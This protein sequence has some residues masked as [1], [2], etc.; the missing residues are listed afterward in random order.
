MAEL[1]LVPIIASGVTGGAIITSLAVNSSMSLWQRFRKWLRY[2]NCIVRLITKE[3]DAALFVELIKRISPHCVDLKHTIHVSLSTKINNN[4]RPISKPYLLPKP[5]DY[6]PIV[7][8]GIT[9]NVLVITLDGIHPVGFEFS[10]KRNRRQVM[11]NFVGAAMVEN[12][13]ANE[14]ILRTYPSFT[15]TR[16]GGEE[17]EDT[18]LT[19]PR[20]GDIELR[21][22]TRRTG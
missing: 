15:P 17:E 16:T 22:R 19:S 20:S 3:T 10:C 14:D 6:L 2:Y 21:N 8:G 12:R 1:A 11:D 13:I 18:L 9:L 4:E 7:I 5:G